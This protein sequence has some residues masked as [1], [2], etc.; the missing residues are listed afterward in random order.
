MIFD[1]GLVSSQ[2]YTRYS[3]R[4]MA[5]ARSTPEMKMITAL[6]RKSSP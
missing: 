1:S 2:W 5:R 6:I 4:P 3:T